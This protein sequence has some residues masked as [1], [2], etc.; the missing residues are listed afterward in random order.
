MFLIHH[1]T[2]CFEVIYLHSLL[3]LCLK[4]NDNEIFLV[5]LFRIFTQYIIKEKEKAIINIFDLNFGIQYDLTSLLNSENPQI[6][7]K[8]EII[9]FIESVLN[10]FSQLPPDDYIPEEEEFE[11]EELNF[12]LSGKKKDFSHLIKWSDQESFFQNLTPSF[13]DLE[14][15][16]INIIFQLLLDNITVPYDLLISSLKAINSYVLYIIPSFFE[17]ISFP[18]IQ[19]FVDKALEVIDQENEEILNL[20]LDTL[21]TLCDR[22]RFDGVGYFI[23]QEG[24]DQT[25]E[26]WSNNPS[27]TQRIDKICFLMEL[28]EEA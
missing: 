4:F 3:N 19:A 2:T 14:N 16:E 11:E 7:I 13:N 26:Y 12:Q 8:I 10:T 20:F 9:K 27:V 24:I 1:N 17:Q 22:N 21:L 18:Q 15:P 5:P 23:E 6:D 28:N 25:R